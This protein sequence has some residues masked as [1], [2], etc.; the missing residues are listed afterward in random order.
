MNSKKLNGEVLLWTALVLI[1]S[2]LCYLPMIFERK[3]IHISQVLLDLKYLFV[4]IPFAVSI[5]FALKHG[6]FKTWFWALFAERVK[7]QAILSCMILG[8]VGVS[9]SVMYCMIVGDKSLFT[10]SYPTAAAVVM[11]CSY[12]FVTASIEEIAWRGFLL[13]KIAAAKG[14][15]VALVYVGM[16]WAIWHIPMWT[17]RN[18]LEFEEV[19]LYFMWTMLVS[20]VLGMLFYRYKNILIVSMAHMVF[21]TCFITPVEYSFILLGCSLVILAFIFNIKIDT[22]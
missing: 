9:F 3:G 22:V 20:L 1:L 18:L 16:V 5:S 19:F 14:K 13:N 15:R 10:S 7:F 21:N 4:T 12:L 11:N 2:S 17:V 8:S 6:Q